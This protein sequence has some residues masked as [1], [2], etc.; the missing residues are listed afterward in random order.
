MEMAPRKKHIGI[1]RLAVLV[2]FL[3]TALICCVSKTVHDERFRD[4]QLLSPPANNVVLADSQN[5]TFGIAGDLH[6]GAADTTR[7]RRILTSAQGEGDSF[8]VLLGDL[9]NEGERQD[10]VAMH[11]AIGDFGFTGKAFTALGNHDIFADGWT[12]YKELNGAATYAFTV[13]NAKFIVLDTG[14]GAVGEKQMEWFEA[15]LKKSRP[16]NLFVVSH[17][18]PVVPGVRTYLRISDDFEAMKLMK[19][20][21]TYAVTAW[22]GAHYHSYLNDVVEGVRYVCA[23]GAGGRRMDPVRD[24]F[25]VQVSVAGTNV[26]YQLRI[27]D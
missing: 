18:L 23:G 7:F 19:L 26:S 9:V 20:A 11:A 4:S 1:E 14:D 6:I 17:Y 5:Y 16:A 12:H 27:V 3:A 15:E 24:Y 22:F 10:V 13:G 2:G 8:M 21:K 25:F